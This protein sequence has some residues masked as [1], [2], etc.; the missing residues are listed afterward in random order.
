MTS[1]HIEHRCFTREI[2]DI[3]IH[4]QF[5]R[6]PNQTF[7]WIGTGTPKLESLCA[8]MPTRLVSYFVMNDVLCS[9]CFVRS[10]HLRRVPTA[11]THLT[12]SM[13]GFSPFNNISI[14]WISNN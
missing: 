8:S 10:D 7:V 9:T 1:G 13:A 4:F 3:P 6:L 11:S 5:I 12:L 2:D 14:F